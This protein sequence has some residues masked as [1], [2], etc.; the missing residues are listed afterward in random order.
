MSFLSFCDLGTSR[1]SRPRRIPQKFSV[2][3]REKSRP[4]ANCSGGVGRAA[5]RTFRSERRPKYD[6]SGCGTA[7]MFARCKPREAYGVRAACR[8]FAIPACCEKMN[9]LRAALQSSWSS[10][11]SYLPSRR[12]RKYAPQSSS[13]S[14]TNAF[15]RFSAVKGS[16]L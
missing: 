15:I 1:H 16:S 10:S 5:S 13:E 11:E 3:R 9:S 4:D 14:F 7:E 8:P 6:A 12:F 2:N